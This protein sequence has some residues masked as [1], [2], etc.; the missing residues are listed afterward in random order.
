MEVCAGHVSKSWYVMMQTNGITNGHQHQVVAR[1]GGIFRYSRA[2]QK[3]CGK[4]NYL[5]V[6]RPHIAYSVSVVSRFLFAPW[7]SHW[8]V[9]IRILWYLRFSPGR[10]LLYSDCGHKWIG[11]FSDADWVGSPVDR[12]S[13][14]IYC[15]FVGGNFCIVEK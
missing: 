8:D 1:S 6:T 11:G 4:L 5:T 14:T 10:G 15:V 7:T 3:T 9:V 13:T 2:I 12:R